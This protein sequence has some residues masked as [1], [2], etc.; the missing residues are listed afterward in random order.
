MAEAPLKAVP[1]TNESIQQQPITTKAT[2]KATPCSSTCPLAADLNERVGDAERLLFYAAE[3]G[4]V[5]HPNVRDAV[6][7]AK[8]TSTDNWNEQT[9]TN[10]L[11]AFTTL[12]TKLKPVTADSLKEC[13]E[14]P[15]V[16]KFIGWYRRV[17]IALAICIVPFSLVTFI[18]SAISEAIR[19][20]IETANLLAVKLGDEVRS[21]RAQQLTK[22]TP[23]SHVSVRDLQEFA[24]NHSRD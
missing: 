9:A 16:K 12:A 22:D 23:P 7:K 24:S 4:I 17:T 21:I 20:D 3:A 5:V 13:A 15:S 11:S 1:S 19:K 18:T 10:F 14:G 6:L 2:D 8:V